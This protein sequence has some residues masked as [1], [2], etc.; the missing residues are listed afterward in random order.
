MIYRTDKNTNK[1]QV[2]ICARQSSNSYKDG[3]TS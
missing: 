1:K 3:Y 2:N